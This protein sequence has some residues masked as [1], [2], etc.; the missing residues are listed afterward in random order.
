MENFGAK[1]TFCL[2]ELHYSGLCFK[3]KILLKR[4]VIYYYETW[5]FVSK[6]AEGLNS[7]QAH[8][9]YKTRTGVLI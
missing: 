6:K 2:P 8:Y 5:L 3:I 7:Y 9:K 4:T 1:R